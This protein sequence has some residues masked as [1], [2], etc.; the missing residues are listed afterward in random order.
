MA[1]N[2]LVVVEDRTAEVS[3]RSE[4]QAIA[5]ERQRMAREIHDGLA[6]NLAALLVRVGLWQDLVD[7]NPAQMH[8]ELDALGNLLRANIREVRRSIFALRPVALEDLGFAPALRAL[9]EDLSEQNQWHV[10][11]Q[12]PEEERLPAL[13]EPVLFRILQEALNNIAKHARAGLVSIELAR[14]PG[15]RLALSIRDDGGGFDPAALDGAV[16][17]GHV[18]LAQM[19][20]RVVDLHGTFELYSQIGRGT[21]IRVTL[22][23][24]KT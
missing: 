6:Q 21:E 14:I 8:R 5:A 7:Q 11:L 17:A 3:R 13:L 18:G 2:S 23:I 4:E 19:R 16:R 24:S 1:L 12:V 9:V 15:E 10:A 22:P 20:E